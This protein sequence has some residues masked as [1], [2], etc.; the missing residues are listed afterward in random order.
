MTR[1]LKGKG[2]ADYDEVHDILFFKTKERDYDRSIELYN[3]VVDIDTENFLTGIQIFEAS[4]FLR[5]P[6]TALRK[7][8]RWDF[9]ANVD[10]NTIEV[11]LKFQTMWR[12]K[13]I[14]KNPIIVESIG[15]NL[16]D[17]EMVC[18]TA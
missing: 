15:E 16:P 14:E 4:K 12:N 9:C 10:K 8:P 13:V 7:I 1:H 18:V 5:I 17:S 2:E 6:K 3:L 11:R